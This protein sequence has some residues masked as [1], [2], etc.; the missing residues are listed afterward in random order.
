MALLDSLI[1]I[2]KLSVGSSG[3][4]AVL[5]FTE[6]SAPGTIDQQ[7]VI[8]RREIEWT[9]ECLAAAATT[10]DIG[11]LC[12]TLRAAFTAVGVL[13]T[14]TEFAGTPRTLAPAGT[15]GG[16]LIGFPRVECQ[17]TPEDSIG[18][19]QR[20]TV[21]VV[22]H[23]PVLQTTGLPGGPSNTA[24]VSHDG[25]YT[26][27]TSD[28]R[29]TTT[30]V[31]GTVRVENG[32]DAKTYTA[33]AIVDPAR[34]AT[35]QLN[36][37]TL[38][39]SKWTIG[40]DAAQVGYEY[41]TAPPGRDTIT[42][43]ANNFPGIQRGEINDVTDRAREGRRVRTVSGWGEG[44]GNAPTEFALAQRPTGSDVF[45]QRARVSEPRVPNGRVDFSYECLSGMEHAS[46]PGIT[47]FSHLETISR[48]GGGRG[49]AAALYDGADP[50]LHQSAKQP[51]VYRQSASIQFRGSPDSITF[52]TPFSLDN[53]D[54]SS[55]RFGNSA[56]GDLQSAFV[57]ARFLY[58]DVIDPVPAA[59]VVFADPAE[60]LDDGGEA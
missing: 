44:T 21:R 1:A 18:V 15:V 17:A 41:T 29:G 10:A 30:Q 47:L 9:L 23:V 2:G 37:G 11:A 6:R 42:I 12:E 38:F 31:R 49:I 59:M 4:Y 55:L 36:D 27:I 25:P 52:P 58:V 33:I 56:Q 24:L 28:E 19:W 60:N 13:V 20:F 54:D 14:L 3:D 40:P 26:T 43:L 8:A 34:A 5:R 50:E 16:C 51:Y 57:D 22:A 39:V 45:V 7:N 46:F 48:E 32:K 53:L 35:T